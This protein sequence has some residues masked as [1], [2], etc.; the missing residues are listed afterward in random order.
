MIAKAGYILL[1]FFD[2]DD[3]MRI[4]GVG[5]KTFVVT[6]RNMDPLL[7]LDP[8][9]PYD[10]S[11]VNEQLLLYKPFNSPRVTILKV[12]KQPDR[13]Y[14]FS[15]CEMTDDERPDSDEEIQSYNEITLKPG[16]VL[17][18]QRTLEFALPSLTGLHA[19]YNPSVIN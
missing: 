10:E 14:L 15:Y 1:T 8:R 4:D 13:S 5:K 11:E 18:I 12:A 7:D 19:L 16:Q 6:T 9:A 2:L 3:D 17:M